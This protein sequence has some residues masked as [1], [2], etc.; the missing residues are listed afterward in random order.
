[1]PDSAESPEEPNQPRAPDALTAGIEF[2]QAL[3]IMRATLES[4]TDAI[5]VTDEKVKVLEFNEKYIGMWKI[6]R[7]I[8]ENG[9]LRE[10]RELMSQNFADPRR[11][12]VR[13]QEIAA[14]AQESL[15]LLELKDGRIFDR[16]SKVLIVE[17]EEQVVYGA[18]AM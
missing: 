10:V 12:M 13:I 14:T 4:T 5:L 17:G 3:V 2:A 9:T 16:F 7:E 1:M 6:P 15:D 11:F 8:L 18:S